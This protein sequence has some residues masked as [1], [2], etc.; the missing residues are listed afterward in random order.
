MEKFYTCLRAAAS[1]KAG[2]YL[3]TLYHPDEKVYGILSTYELSLPLPYQTT[4]FVKLWKYPCPTGPP[5]LFTPFQSR[6]GVLI[7][8]FH[9]VTSFVKNDV[10]ILVE[11]SMEALPLLMG[12]ASICLQTSLLP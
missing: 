5:D 3:L 9:R 12:E 7:E 2:R 6:L 10:A 8:S 4:A 1:A 11:H